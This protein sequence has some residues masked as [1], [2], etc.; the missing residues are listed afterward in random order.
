MRMFE[1]GLKVLTVYDLLVNSSK[2]PEPK[3]TYGDFVVDD[4][5]KKIPYETVLTH[6]ADH[7]H[8][9]RLDYMIRFGYKDP[10]GE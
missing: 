10:R 4:Q 9:M 5:G 8:G 2:Q 3:F 6:K 1:D 7:G